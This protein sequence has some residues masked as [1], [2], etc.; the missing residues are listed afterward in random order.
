MNIASRRD[1]IGSSCPLLAALLA[2]RCFG[3][4]SARLRLGLGLA[5]EFGKSWARA[6]S[7]DGTKICLEDWDRSGYP[8]RI[9]DLGT[10]R[11]TYSG[12]FHLRVLDV[13]F[14]ADGRA[15][16]LNLPPAPRSPSRHGVV[17]ELADNERSGR[18]RSFDFA[19]DHEIARPLGGRTLLLERWAK[20]PRH[21]AS[22]SLIDFSSGREIA[23]ADIETQRGDSLPPSGVVLSGDRKMLVYFLNNQVVCRRSEDLGVVWVHQV[24]HGLSAEPLAASATGLSF[25]AVI[26]S[27]FRDKNNFLNLTP[28]YIATYSGGTGDE[29]S[30][31]QLRPKYGIALSPN[32]KLLAVPVDEPGEGGDL[33]ATASVYDSVSGD[34]LTSVFHDRIPSG[35]RQFLLS[36]CT[37]E[38]TSDGKYLVTSGMRT[39]VWKVGGEP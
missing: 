16:F 1:L 24:E 15:L 38:F 34:M 17:V 2:R 28:L 21:L 13:E 25:A 23:R 27:G 14:F 30:R 35:R 7:P 22:L 26:K 11:E 20:K 9:V 29:V 10:W 32:G 12:G 5:H 37:A 39:K 3:A 18:I 6:V 31:L 36:G 19:E 33:F 4:P 8:L